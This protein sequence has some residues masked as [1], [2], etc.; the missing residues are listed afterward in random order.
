MPAPK[1][2]LEEIQE[3]LDW[4]RY[5]TVTFAIW[6]FIFAVS[7][8]LQSTLQEDCTA[9]SILFW[10][11]IGLAIFG[12]TGEFFTDVISL[13]EFDE[14]KNTVVPILTFGPCE[15]IE[16]GKSLWVRMITALILRVFSNATLFGTI[17]LASSFPWFPKEG[18]GFYG[19]C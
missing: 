16:D 7:S 19:S 9:A 6:G 3:F 4:N 15:K 18:N 14:S 12:T 8:Q 13:Y 5:M 17:I 11:G 10:L 1:D 2:I